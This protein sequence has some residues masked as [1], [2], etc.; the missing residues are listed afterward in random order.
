MRIQIMPEC[1]VDTV[2]YH[3]S[4][5]FLPPSP[6]PRATYVLLI[7]YDVCVCGNNTLDYGPFFGSEIVPYSGLLCVGNPESKGKS[8]GPV[9]A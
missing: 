2:T 1:T 8:R 4:D 9:D 7:C 3:N 6:S 5:I